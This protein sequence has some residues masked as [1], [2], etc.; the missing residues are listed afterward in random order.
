MC[1]CMCL[2]ASSIIFR[3]LHEIIW[4]CCS[5]KKRICFIVSKINYLGKYAA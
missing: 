4:E 1:R 5:V 2:I 3:Y